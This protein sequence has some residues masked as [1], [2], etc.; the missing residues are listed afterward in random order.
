[1]CLDID[2]NLD[3]NKLKNCLS[4]LKPYIVLWV[5]VKDVGVGLFFELARCENVFRHPHRL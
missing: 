1:M 2:I 5:Q 4:E 3:R